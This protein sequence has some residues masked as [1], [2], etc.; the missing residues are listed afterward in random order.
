[1]KQGLHYI[2]DKFR[3]IYFRYLLIATITIL[4][5]SYLRWMFDFK[6]GV[7][8]LKEDLLDFWIPFILPFLPTAIWLRKPLRILNLNGKTGVSDHPF[9]VC[10]EHSKCFQIDKS[11][12]IDIE[13]HTFRNRVL[14]SFRNRWSTN[15][16]ERCSMTAEFPHLISSPWVEGVITARILSDFS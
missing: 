5:Y 16:G 11:L 3:F 4:V 12:I 8:H 13:I 6:L 2:K 7:L 15:S 14:R 9:P 10:G 1:M